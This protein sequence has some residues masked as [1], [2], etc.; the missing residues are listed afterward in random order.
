M[1][2]NEVFKINRLLFF[3]LFFDEKGSD[4]EGPEKP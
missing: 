4:C 2:D 1:P 3:F